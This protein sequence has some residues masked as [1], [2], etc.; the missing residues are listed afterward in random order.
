MHTVSFV[1]KPGVYD[2]EFHALDAEIE[3][4][5]QSLDGFIGVE[6]WVNSDGDV[7]NSVYY[8]RDME[9]IKVFSRFDHH[10]DAK[11]RYK[12]WY[13]G[14]HIVISEIVSNYGDG[15]VTSLAASK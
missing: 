6:R 4:F 15:G 12:N 8:W 9:T 5:A 11:K 2:D 10:I 14:Y 13:E 1:F 3:A 7:R